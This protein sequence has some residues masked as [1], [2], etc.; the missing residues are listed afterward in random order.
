MI[1]PCT[2]VTTV[3]AAIREFCFKVPLAFVIGDVEGH[4]EIL[5]T[6][7][8]THNTKMLSRECNCTIDDAD[9]HEVECKYIRASDLTC[10]RDSHNKS[11]LKELCFHNVRNA[12]DKV[13]FGDNEYGIHRAMMSKV[14]HAIQK[15]WYVCTLSALYKMLSGHPM[16]FL[17]SLSR[18]VFPPSVATKVTVPSCF[19][20]T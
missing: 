4:D 3:T 8:H 19:F 5:C 6:R 11:A 2:F 9:N 17:Y 16:E 18:R 12:F 1:F 7:Y 14:L 13:C 20:S 10:L 15:R